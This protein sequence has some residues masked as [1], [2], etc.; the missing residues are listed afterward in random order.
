MDLEL[1]ENL[2]NDEILELFDNSVQVS[3][4][5]C[6]TENGTPWQFGLHG[7]HTGGCK[8]QLTSVSLCEQHCESKGFTIFINP[9][10]GFKQFSSNCWCYH[11]EQFSSWGRC[12][13]SN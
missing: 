4:C 9:E 1:I 5:W 6:Q 2:N 13:F 11:T 10:G 12:P 3:S 8:L 7:A